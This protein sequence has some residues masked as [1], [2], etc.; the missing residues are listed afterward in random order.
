MVGKVHSVFKSQPVG[1]RF[2]NNK[3]LA[4]LR[5]VGHFLFLTVGIRLLMTIFMLVEL[6]VLLLCLMLV[7][8]CG[9]KK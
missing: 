7:F 8:I 3:P 6:L 2:I 9:V 1:L 4:L 5:C